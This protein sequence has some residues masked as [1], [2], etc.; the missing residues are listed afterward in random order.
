MIWFK[1]ADHCHATWLLSN[2][3]HLPSSASQR[4]K[5]PIE[6]SNS[7]HKPADKLSKA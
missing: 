1:N 5:F 2:Y 7:S 3:Q 4:D 6:T